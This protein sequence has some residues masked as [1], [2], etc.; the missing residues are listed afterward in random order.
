MNHPP[1]TPITLIFYLIFLICENPRHL[2]ISQGSYT[3]INHH[4]PEAGYD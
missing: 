3:R 4:P 2:R 1:I